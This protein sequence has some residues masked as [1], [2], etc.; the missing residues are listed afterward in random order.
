MVQESKSSKK[1]G[2]E[3]E[4]KE[5]IYNPDTGKFE[6]G[7]APANQPNSSGGSDDSSSG[8]EEPL[9]NRKES[10]DEKETKHDP[11]AL[12]FITGEAATNFSTL[13]WNA[14]SENPNSPSL[15]PIPGCNVPRHNPDDDNQ[16]P[17]INVTIEIDGPLK[18]FMKPVSGGLPLDSQGFTLSPG[19]GDTKKF[20]FETK[21]YDEVFGAGGFTNLMR[22]QLYGS[23]IKITVVEQKTDGTRTR[24]I[25]TYYQNRWVDVIDAEQAK[26][27]TGNTAAF[28]RTLADGSGNFVREKNVDYFL[29]SNVNTSFNGSA[30]EFN[31]GNAISNNGQAVWKFDP[32][33][34]GQKSGDFKIQVN[35]PK[36]NNLEVGEIKAKGKATA[37]TKLGIDISSF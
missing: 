15:P 21:T 26:N 3:E 18:D 10:D 25:Y 29:P 9:E 35:D 6:Y 34:S 23:Q 30:T 20:G 17:F 24:D 5:L 27:K 31:L 4:K 2:G 7:V 32:T 37:P 28:H 36:I 1:D 8:E 16:Q 14:P 13:T 22:D 19:T 11:V 33:N 12:N